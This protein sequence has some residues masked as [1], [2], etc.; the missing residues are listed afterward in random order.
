MVKS[1]DDVF[2]GLDA[3]ADK[4]VKAATAAQEKE[5]DTD[6]GGA[7]GAIEAPVGSVV[8]VA[9]VEKKSGVRKPR[10]KKS[11]AA[12]P[13]R[14]ASARPRR[15]KKPVPV[16]P[17]SVVVPPARPGDAKP[18]DGKPRVTGA[19]VSGDARGNLYRQVK[20]ALHQ[21]QRVKDGLLKAGR[22]GKYK[23]SETDQAEFEA[24]IS[25][26]H[27][28][29]KD[30]VLGQEVSEEHVRILE[31]AKEHLLAEREKLALLNSGTAQGDRG[32]RAL[33]PGKR[34]E[35]LSIEEMQERSDKWIQETKELIPTIDTLDA[36][37]ALTGFKGDGARRK[38]AFNFPDELKPLFREGTPP[39]IR[40]AFGEKVDALMEPWRKQVVE[41][42]FDQPNVKEGFVKFLH[43]SFSALSEGTLKK[44]KF[45]SLYLGKLDFRGIKDIRS[46]ECEPLLN[47][48]LEAF[49]TRY[50]PGAEAQYKATG[51]GK[52]PERKKRGRASSPPLDA[53]DAA[54][55]TPMNGGR[56]SD[57]ENQKYLARLAADKSAGKA[58]SEKPN[59]KERTYEEL[60]EAAERGGYYY[61]FFGAL[62]SGIRTMKE[63]APGLVAQKK[64]YGQQIADALAHGMEDSF[65]TVGKK[66][67][68][69]SEEQKIFVGKI[70]AS[71]IEKFL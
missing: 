11:T 70:V 35:R 60:Y 59:A 30:Q 14:P 16:A 25:R 68:W 24:E 63:S 32:K 26:I 6:N 34:K 40:R 55:Q 2:S 31:V 21:L 65:N 43:N 54:R 20:D 69:S 38:R 23:V 29:A 9:T 51:N 12:A 67:G 1:L 66:L 41:I 28:K 50:Y 58:T 64:K 7:L 49:W 39:D 45:L 18:R 53:D 62:A 44:E 22:S 46:K 52:K 56:V 27:D 3:L 71:G 57:Y 48:K 15:V 5:P 33:R 13:A 36:A 47:A 37:Q 17:T 42:Y 4:S 10:T 8:P 19:P 61:T